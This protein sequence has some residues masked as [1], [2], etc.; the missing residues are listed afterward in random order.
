MPI[1]L[2]IVESLNISVN[3]FSN[4]LNKT[5]EK[6]ALDFSVSRIAFPNSFF[7]TLMTQPIS[8]LFISGRAL[9]SVEITG[10]Q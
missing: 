7:L 1:F 10:Q 2:I 8:E 6:F 5:F 4:P 9:M 3:T